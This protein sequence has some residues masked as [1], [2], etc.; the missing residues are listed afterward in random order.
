MGLK[1][2][3]ENEEWE[4]GRCN[5]VLRVRVESEEAIVSSSFG[6]EL[7]RKKERKKEEEDR[8]RSWLGELDLY[9]IQ[10]FILFLPIEI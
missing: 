8:I 6:E 2:R 9:I 1:E 10:I 4:R 5:G 3:G 7:N